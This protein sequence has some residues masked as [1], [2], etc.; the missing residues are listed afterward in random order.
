MRR[1]VTLSGPIT[2]SALP[3]LARGDWTYSKLA[4]GLEVGRCPG[5][6]RGP[7]LDWLGTA[8]G[9]ERGVAAF[10]AR[11]KNLYAKALCKL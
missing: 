2:C 7:V 3:L 9:E 6:E 5:T 4:S 8:E 10:G 1:R 11:R